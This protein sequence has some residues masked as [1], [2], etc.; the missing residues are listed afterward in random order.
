MFSG[1]SGSAHRREGQIRRVLPV[2]SMNFSFHSFLKEGSSSMS[3][4]S[5]G[6]LSSVQ[7]RGGMW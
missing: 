3:T 6:M 7:H 1:F 5:G 2:Y 4:N